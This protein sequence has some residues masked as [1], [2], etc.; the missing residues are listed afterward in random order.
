MK[1][2]TKLLLAVSAVC[3]VNAA[4]AQ[5]P[6]STLFTVNGSKITSGQLDQWVSVVV[7]GGGKDTPELRQALLNELIIQEAITQDAKKTGLLTKGDNAFKL[8]LAEKNAVTELWFAQYFTGHPITE[9]DIRAEYDKQVTMSKDPKNAKEYQLSQIV[10]ANESDGNQ[11]L[12]QLKSGTSFAALA[13]EKSLDK[14][15]A[16]NGGLLGWALPTQLAPPLN[17]LVPTLSKGDVA[18]KPIQVGNVWHIIKVDD[19]KP[20]VMPSFDQSR[21]N[22]TKG[23]VQQRRQDAIKQ[24]MQNVKIA[25]GN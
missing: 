12:A 4:L 13:K 16:A 23:L 24:L 7:S 1:R 14:A 25:K 18:S 3:L 11:M 6:G 15:S 20:F 22:I 17:D 5:G 8:K 19:T 2:Y 9:A 10:V 21:D